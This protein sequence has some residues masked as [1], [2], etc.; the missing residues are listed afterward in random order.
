M[1]YAKAQPGQS[2]EPGTKV[3]AYFATQ[4]TH[5]IFIADAGWRVC[6]TA[7]EIREGENGYRAVDLRV[8]RAGWIHTSANAD[9][10]EVSR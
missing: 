5:G 1:A 8:G 2:I 10:L 9:R 3:R 7:G 6:V 4:W